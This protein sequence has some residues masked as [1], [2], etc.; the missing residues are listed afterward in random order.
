MDV[1]YP[2]EYPFVGSMKGHVS[3]IPYTGVSARVY[4]AEKS[5]RRVYY[6]TVLFYSVELYRNENMPSIYL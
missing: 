2:Y 3:F 6:S 4:Y 1:K 5:F